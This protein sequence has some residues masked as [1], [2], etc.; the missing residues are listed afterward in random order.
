MTSAFVVYSP[1]Y[2]IG[3]FEV[4]S[5][6]TTAHRSGYVY[7]NT[8]S[9]DTGKPSEHDET[10]G[11]AMCRKCPVTDAPS[12]APT[13]NPTKTPTRVPTG[14]PTFAH[15]T[16]APSNSPTNA[17]T[18]PLDLSTSSAW[19]GTATTSEV[20]WHSLV[21]SFFI[22]GGQEYYASPGVWRSNPPKSQRR[23]LMI[24][25]GMPYEVAN[26]TLTSINTGY[27]AADGYAWTA[28]DMPIE[29]CPEA[30]CGNNDDA[31]PE[32]R[33]WCGA[34]I[35]ITVTSGGTEVGPFG[36][37]GMDAGGSEH[38]ATF[39]CKRADN[40]SPVGRYIR[41][42]AI[43]ETAHNANKWV[44]FTDITAHLSNVQSSGNSTGRRLLSH[45]N[46]APYTHPDA[47][48][49]KNSESSS[50]SFESWRTL[51]IGSSQMAKV[52]WRCANEFDPDTSDAKSPLAT[53]SILATRTNVALR[54]RIRRFSDREKC[55][56]IS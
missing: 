1:Y 4:S 19:W 17:P 40:Q 51:E 23:P 33:T 14:T 44:A 10:S 6:A 56:C 26:V 43:T 39:D 35:S 46:V 52:I 31:N 54:L 28:D 2:P 21:G 29:I 16:D 41:I 7:Y 32:T 53:V 3:C 50:N 48:I 13:Q 15:S 42:G 5:L 24:D 18:A 12:R 8:Y 55:R 25:L 9:T 49:N 37:S 34:T 45:G 22:D 11:F 36:T 38:V 30:T 27:S 20:P 47:L